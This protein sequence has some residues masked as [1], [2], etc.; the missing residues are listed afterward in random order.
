[1]SFNVG[2]HYH[3]AEPGRLID[4]VFLCMQLF[5]EPVKKVEWDEVYFIGFIDTPA[6]RID[7]WEV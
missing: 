7:Q 1:M 6:G 2:R 5:A 4:R 3:I